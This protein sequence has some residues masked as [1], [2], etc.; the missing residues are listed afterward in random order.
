MKKAPKKIFISYS[1]HDNHYKEALL[2]QL[3]G[4]GDDIVT[5]DDSG[6]RA[7]DEWDPRIKH[8]LLTADICI[9]LVSANSMSTDYIQNHE[10]PLIEQRCQKREC[11][12]VSVIVDSCRWQ[13]KS[14][15]KYNV[16][17]EKGKPVT[18][19]EHW[20]TESKAWLNVVEGIDE[21]IRSLPETALPAQTCYLSAY[22]DDVVIHAAGHD[23]VFAETFKTEL[24]KYLAAKL[25]GLNFRLRLQTNQDDFANAA[26]AIVLLSDNYLQQYGDHFQTLKQLQ[27]KRL[28]LAMVNKTDK[29]QSLDEVVEYEFCHQTRHNTLT[30]QA[31]D[32]VY[33]SIMG[34]LVV[35]LDGYLQQLKSQQQSREELERIARQTPAVDQGNRTTVF[36]NVAPEDRDLGKQIQSL[37]AKDYRLVST[38]PAS[39]KTRTDIGNKYF[40]CHAVLLVYVD[41]SDEWIDYQLLACAQAASEHQKTFKI[42]AIHSD[43]RQIQSIN[44]SLPELV[45]E[46]YYCPPETIHDYLPRFVEALK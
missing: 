21:I 3:S 39:T 1:Q 30:Y 36:I 16:L 15:A 27:Q 43:A 13:K 11:V 38:L 26:T 37:L 22:A 46:E 42:I 12:L 10:L 24:Q 25:G 29:P 6:I 9:Y 31:A 7:G 28:L 35:E 8:Q 5:W 34:E 17:P 33:Q 19:K 32:S 18:D 14:F 2:K 41:A 4:L 44:V 40:L 20:P 45:I 23:V